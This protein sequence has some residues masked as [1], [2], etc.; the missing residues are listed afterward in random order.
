MSRTE[1]DWA[2]AL[3]TSLVGGITTFIGTY[4]QFG[5]A[6]AF[7]FVAI[8]FSLVGLLFWFRSTEKMK[9]LFE[10][11]SQFGSRPWHFFLLAISLGVIGLVGYS[12]TWFSLRLTR[13][14]LPL[15]QKT[16]RVADVDFLH[17]RFP[18][19]RPSNLERGRQEEERVFESTA[20]MRWGAYFSE[21]K[22]GH[23]V[24]YVES[25]PIP[26]DC[27]DV[28]VTC[29]LRA[30]MAAREVAAYLVSS[31][32]PGSIWK[33]PNMRKQSHS[34]ANGSE[35]KVKLDSPNANERLV[36]FMYGSNIDP[37]VNIKNP[38][39]AAEP[40]NLLYYDYFEFD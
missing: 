20:L 3:Y 8:L 34:I 38:P 19:T 9:W 11:A 10:F 23:R 4:Q 28:E 27:D 22:P 15:K 40:N 1:N 36:V 32:E 39:A 29:V 6:G 37:I 33:R 7:L 18:T 25:E 2:L 30:P 16:L 35:V 31:T 17:H 21:M 24:Y 13:S 14:H 12:A 5:L 26:T